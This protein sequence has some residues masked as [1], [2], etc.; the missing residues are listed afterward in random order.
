MI[1][2]ASAPH[3]QPSEGWQTSATGAKQR[4]VRQNRK[5]V[6]GWVAAGGSVESDPYASTI[7]GGPTHDQRSHS[8][9]T[10]LVG[11][12]VLCRA[13]VAD[14]SAPTGPAMGLSGHP[15]GDLPAQQLS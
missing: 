5:R 1:L 8:G 2:C 6:I 4:T 10:A 7:L 3:A 9:D 11:R 14:G 12:A 15:A 13:V